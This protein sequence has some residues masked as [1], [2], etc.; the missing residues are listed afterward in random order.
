M[1]SDKSGLASRLGWVLEETEQT[2]ERTRQV[3][4]EYVERGDEASLDAALE[5]SRET[6][7]ILDLLEA[8]GAYM[9][10]REL[11]LFC[12]LYTSPSPRDS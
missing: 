10:D 1:I 4:A 6:L 8:E 7:G 5:Y 3:F 11:V 9:L 12:L 2:L